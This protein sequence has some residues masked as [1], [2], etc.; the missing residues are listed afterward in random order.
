[1]TG[2]DLQYT[3]DLYSQDLAI[4]V[5]NNCKFPSPGPCSQ[6]VLEDAE[7]TPEEARE[8]SCFCCVTCT[9]FHMERL[10][11]QAS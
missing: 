11:F 3:A 2:L 1:M 6:M 10:Y 8:D 4:K 7:E 9:K 5:G